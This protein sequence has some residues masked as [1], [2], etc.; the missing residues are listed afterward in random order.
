MS[1]A[2][3]SK[4]RDQLQR[5]ISRGIML[6][7]KKMIT[8]EAKHEMSKSPSKNKTKQKKHGREPG[9]NIEKKN[10]SKWFSGIKLSFHRIPGVDFVP[11]IS[12]V[13][14][15]FKDIGCRIFYYSQIALTLMIF[16]TMNSVSLLNSPLNCTDTSTL[17]I[18]FIPQGYKQ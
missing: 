3:A 16:I 9:S 13:I 8:E 1:W 17:G 14:I 15:G 2:G 11:T 18:S 7:G 4:E 5:L 12:I 10:Q 6:R